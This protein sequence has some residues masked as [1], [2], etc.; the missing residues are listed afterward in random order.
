MFDWEQLLNEAQKARVASFCGASAKGN[1][2]NLVYHAQ[3][4]PGDKFSLP[5]EL[6]QIP[7]LVLLSGLPN[8]L[9]AQFW[10]RGQA[11]KRC[12]SGNIAISAFARQYML[13]SD[14]FSLQLQTPAGSVSLGHDR[15]GPFYDARPEP[16]RPIVHKA[17][18]RN[19]LGSDFLAGAFSGGASDYALL[20]LDRAPA[21]LR[22]R[23]E[24]L[25]RFSRR[26]LVA[27]CPLGPGNVQM[28][29]FAPQYGNDEDSATGSAAVQ[30]AEYLWRRYH[31]RSCWIIQQ[32]A[33]GGL[34]QTEKL[35]RQLRVRGEAWVH[36]C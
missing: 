35:S 18:W 9:R 22:L 3:P 31:W 17:L 34:I 25:L 11:V 7:N 15:F 36:Q 10:D 16:Q 19:L 20:E 30:V 27:F 26:A 32:S 24:R 33:A 29:Y 8:A 14:R 6:R 23:T 12:G 13:D 4:P 28:R 5:D 1:R 2:H 21:D